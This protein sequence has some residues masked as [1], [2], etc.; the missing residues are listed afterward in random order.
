VIALDVCHAFERSRGQLE[1][2][3]TPVGAK[4]ACGALRLVEDGKVTALIPIRSE[5]LPRLCGELREIWRR[6]G[7]AW[8]K[9]DSPFAR[10]FQREETGK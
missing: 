1:V 7:G 9:D 2:C 5:E 10:C 6:T 3:I 8:R 4:V